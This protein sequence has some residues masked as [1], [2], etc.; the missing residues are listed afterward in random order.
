MPDD[1]QGEFSV[2]VRLPRGTSY[3]RTEEF[4]KPIEK[5]MLALRVR[6]DPTGEFSRVQQYVGNGNGN[7][8]ITMK[9]LEERTMSQQEMMRRM[10]AHAAQVPGCADQRVGRHGHLRRVDGRQ[11]GRRRRR[12]GG[13]GGNRAAAIASRS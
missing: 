11:P 4:V 10:R 1:D 2:N 3:A 12:S 7:F 13:G 5:E 9:P 6:R 8:N